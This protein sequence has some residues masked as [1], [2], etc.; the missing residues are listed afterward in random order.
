MLEALQK[1]PKRQTGAHRG[2]PSLTG[3]REGVPLGASSQGYSVMIIWV[4]E[5]PAVR[6]GYPPLP[7][8]GRELAWA[9]AVG[10]LLGSQA[11]PQPDSKR[12]CREVVCN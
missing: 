2:A 8:A 5:C 7:G 4:H 10:V 12:R 6:A 1:R 3:R 11:Q 9:P